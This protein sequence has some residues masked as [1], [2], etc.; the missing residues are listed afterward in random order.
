MQATCLQLMLPNFLIL[1][2]TS[3]LQ[4]FATLHRCCQPQLQLSPTITA[5][6]TAETC[7]LDAG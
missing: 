1:L 4:S 3:I 7:S 5:R 2:A 6:W